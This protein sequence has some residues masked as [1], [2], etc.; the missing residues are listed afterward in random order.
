MLSSLTRSLRAN[1]KTGTMLPVWFVARHRHENFVSLLS[2]SINRE[3]R[4]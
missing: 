4:T 3:D 2:G 1:Q